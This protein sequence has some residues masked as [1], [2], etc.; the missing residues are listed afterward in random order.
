[1]GAVPGLALL[2]GRVPVG[3]IDGDL[4]ALQFLHDGVQ[5]RVTQAGAVPALLLLLSPPAEPEARGGSVFGLRGSAGEPGERRPQLVHH[6]CRV[7]QRRHEE[8]PHLH[9]RHPS[10]TTAIHSALL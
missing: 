9:D 3:L 4:D 7:T 8:I 1:M 5:D 10:N 6:P 2:Q